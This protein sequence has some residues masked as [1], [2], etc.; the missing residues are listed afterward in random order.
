MSISELAQ[1]FTELEQ[2]FANFLEINKKM[3]DECPICMDTIDPYKNRVTTECGH[4]FHCSCLMTNVSHN[5]FACPYCRT[6]MAE[7]VEE[8]HGY[9]DD[10]STSSWYYGDDD[11]SVDDSSVSVAGPGLEAHVL[12]GM[13]WF[14]QRVDPQEDEDDEDSVWETD[15]EESVWEP[16][17]EGEQEI[18]IEAEILFE[19]D[20]HIGDY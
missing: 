15:D 12:R 13:R 19:G 9:N 8:I 14:F 18:I 20:Y 4:T 17:I 2:S 16:D 11:D 3:M 5:G 10:Y 7:E 6:A 1:S